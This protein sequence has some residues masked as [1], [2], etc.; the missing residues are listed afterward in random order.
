ML[1]TL[2]DCSTLGGGLDLKVFEKYG[3]VEYYDKTPY[4]KVAERI[5][6]SDVVIINK[7]KLNSETLSLAENLKLICVFAT[8][9]DNIDLDYCRKK[10]IAVC[11]VKGYS[12]DS[13]AQLTIAM[14]LQII[15]RIPEFTKYV[16][17]GSYTK[18][19]VQNYLEPQFNEISGKTW[20]VI[21][22]GNIGKK[23]AKIADAFGCKI[24]VNKRT[25]TEDYENATVEKICKE[26]DIISIHTPLNHETRGLIG[27]K[28]L[29]LMKKTAVLIN[30]ARG[31][32]TDENAVAD[33]IKK[34]IIGGF[35]A[36]VYSVEPFD[37]KHPF[38]EI[39]NYNNVCLT[40]HMGWGALEARIR[41]LN[42]ITKN[43]DA[44]LKGETRNR[45][46]LI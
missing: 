15:N 8:G 33:A 41:C 31:A 13:V 36:D 4:E 10:G 38:N 18:S 39:L 5:K 34:G 27:K 32:V 7:V 6:N 23:V 45:V 42:E 37:E 19:G 9:Y 26:A 2:L 40:P 14:A 28:E 3:D 21:G 29:S 35:G 17:D 24:L 30:V 11:N 1:I 16:Q 43:I 46:D 44:F 20:G 25:P 12:T 22:Y